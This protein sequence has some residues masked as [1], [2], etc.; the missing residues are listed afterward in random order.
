MLGPRH[1]RRQGWG[2]GEGHPP[3]DA[4]VHRGGMRIKP[5]SKVLGNVTV[6]LSA[7]KGDHLPR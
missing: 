3:A 7:S 4:D 5:L 6:E 2:W 1:S